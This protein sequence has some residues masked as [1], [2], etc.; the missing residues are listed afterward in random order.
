MTFSLSRPDLNNFINPTSGNALALSFTQTGA[1]LG[2]DFSFSEL[3]ADAALYVPL[4]SE[5]TPATSFSSLLQFLE[6]F[7][8]SQEK[9]FGNRPLSPGWLQ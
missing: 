2:G 3:L 9:K 5:V 8:R 1:F 4:S 7:G 6:N